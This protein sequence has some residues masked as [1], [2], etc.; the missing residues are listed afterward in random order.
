MTLRDLQERGYMNGNK[1]P[2]VKM[3]KVRFEPSQETLD[4][5]H[6]EKLEKLRVKGLDLLS[7]EE[8]KRYA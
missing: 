3:P 2:K 4:R 7:P 6:A 1:G 5:I 8:R